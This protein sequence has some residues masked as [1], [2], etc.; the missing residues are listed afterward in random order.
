MSHCVHPSKGF[1][2]FDNVVLHVLILFVLLSALFI[3]YIQKL[4]S[5]GFNTEFNHV[6][7]EIIEPGKIK[8][9]LEKRETLTNDSLAKLLKIKKVN[10][11]VQ[12]QLTSMVD[13]LK[14][15][16]PDDIKG[17]K[18]GFKKVSDNYKSNEDPLR[19][20]N[21]EGVK[22]QIIIV[23]VF[24]IIIAFI[25]NVMSRKFGNCGILK[26]LGIELLIVFLF[27]GG[28]EFWFF[29]NVAKKYVPVHLD[30]MVKTFKEKMVQIIGTV[31][32]SDPKINPSSSSS[33]SSS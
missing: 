11:N 23:I 24:L 31:P 9:I 16:T 10:S 17:I 30:V 26:H 13:Y 27:I 6:V 7:D 2:L 33:S 18:S 12:S 29:T 32:P 15:L 28:I 21:N 5:E 1:V 8:E 14:K 25:V 22:T 3:F 19:K 20:E 4:T